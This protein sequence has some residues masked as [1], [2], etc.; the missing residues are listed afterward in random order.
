M[1]P[2]P[3]HSHLN[4]IARRSGSLSPGFGPGEK[5]RQP[6]VCLIFSAW[7]APEGKV[8]LVSWVEVFPRPGDAGGLGI[9]EGCGCNQ[10]GDQNWGRGQGERVGA[11]REA[12]SCALWLPTA[13]DFHTPGHHRSRA[14]TSKRPMERWGHPVEQTTW[15]E[16]AGTV[17][18][19]PHAQ[20]H[21]ETPDT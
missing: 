3:T 4:I 17:T 15:K 2:Q 21:P 1:F 19:L 14:L 8:G 10:G 18:I 20:A 9:Q 7:A 16:G 11:L 13:P 5:Q 6:E 12:V